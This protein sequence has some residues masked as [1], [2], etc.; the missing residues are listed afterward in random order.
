MGLRT[1]RTWQV[2]LHRRHGRTR[3]GAPA[4]T[5]AT[6]SGSAIWARV[7]STASHTPL[8]TAPI[9]WT[10]STTE[11][12]STTA[13]RSGTAARTSRHRSRLKPSGSWWSGRVFSAEKIAPRT[14][15]R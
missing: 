6:R 3:S 15:T 2:W 13:T 11:P 14:T 10:G 9:A 4:A 8:A 7:I 12:C 1:S 5:L